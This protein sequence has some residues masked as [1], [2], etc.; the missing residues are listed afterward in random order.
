MGNQLLQQLIHDGK[1]IIKLPVVIAFVV[2]TILVFGVVNTLVSVVVS[3][4]LAS[5]Y[6]LLAWSWLNRKLNKDSKDNK[7]NKETKTDVNQ[8][9]QNKGA[10][11][12]VQAD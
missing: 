1:Q 3:L 7:D 10:D 5:G 11:E 12:A 4:L 9:S 8:Q 2:V 6:Y